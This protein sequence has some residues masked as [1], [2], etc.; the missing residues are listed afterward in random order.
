MKW[1]WTYLKAILLIFVM[2]IQILLILGLIFTIA[3]SLTGVLF[4]T[5]LSFIAVI[6]IFPLL[7]KEADWLIDKMF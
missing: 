4:G 2:T 1:Y 3:Y 6:L 7:V 5:I